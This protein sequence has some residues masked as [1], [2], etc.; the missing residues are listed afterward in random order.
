VFIDGRT[1]HLYP[2]ALVERYAAA[3][4]DPALFAALAAEYDLQWAIVRAR[5]GESFS[6]PIARD[7][8]WTMVYLDDCAAVY[9]RKDGPNGALAAGG[10]RLMRHL[11]TPPEGPILPALRAILR[12][13]AA[14]AI[15]QD[16]SSLRARA[17]AAAAGL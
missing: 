4:H 6:E 3:E 15:A 7:A 11:T 13:D 5:P 10:Y 9:V 2:P 16:P 12:H 1:A 8:K 17:F 14:L